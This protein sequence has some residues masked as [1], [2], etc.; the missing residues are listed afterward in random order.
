M[1]EWDK[2]GVYDAEISPLMAKIIEI[3]KRESIPMAATFQYC[4]REGDGPGFCTTTL[5]NGLESERMRR[6]ILAMQP[7]RPVTLAETIT[8]DPV[9]GRTNISIRRIT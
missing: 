1:S 4:D 3:C 8:T 2:E 5:P 7:D 9:T 6:V